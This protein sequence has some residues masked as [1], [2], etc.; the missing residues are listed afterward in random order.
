MPLFHPPG[1][2]LLD[3]TLRRDGQ[4]KR[5]TIHTGDLPDYWSCRLLTGNAV[6]VS[7][8]FTKQAVEATVREWEAEIAEA[9]VDGWR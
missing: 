6:T 8:C 9:R 1:A 3:V 7:G 4:V 5:W 2:V